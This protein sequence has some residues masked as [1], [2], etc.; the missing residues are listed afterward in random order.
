[1]TKKELIKLIKYVGI[2]NI[3]FKKVTEEELARKL[4]EIRE[5]DNK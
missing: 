4:K 2:R 5:K 3:L 1:M